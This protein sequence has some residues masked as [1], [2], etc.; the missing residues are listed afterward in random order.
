MSLTLPKVS[1]LII[2]YNQK[3]FIADAI[4]GAINQ[5][6]ENLEVVVSDDGS[7]DGTA[8][9]ISDFQKRFPERLIAVLNRPNAGITINS[10]RGLKKCNGKYLA[11]GYGD[12]IFLPGKISAQVAWFEADEERVL[13]GHHAEVF[14]QDGS[15][16]S[17]LTPKV[18][19]EGRGADLLIRQGNLFAATSI[20]VRTSKIPPHGYDEA[21]PIVSD[22]IFWIEVLATGGKFGYVPG[23][24]ARYR[25]HSFNVT[26]K[27]IAILKDVDKTLNIVK[28]RYPQYKKS[29]EYALRKHVKYAEAVLRIQNKENEQARKICLNLIKDYPFDPKV[30]LRLLQSFF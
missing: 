24:Y 4:E 25:R 3:D 16:K 2:C 18:L 9:I 28:E 17:Y 21:M 19:N 10:N 27:S 12:D 22:Y 8:E 13:C 5:D 20:M 11:I 30:Y 6:Y 15:Q 26:S 1:I 29:C 14:F 7:T 23:V